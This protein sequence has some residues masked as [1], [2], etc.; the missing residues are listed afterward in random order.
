[1]GLMQALNFKNQK[2]K[3]INMYKDILNKNLN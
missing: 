2:N 1:M 3:K